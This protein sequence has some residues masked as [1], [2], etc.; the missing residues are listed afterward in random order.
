MLNAADGGRCDVGRA[1][2]GQTGSILKE[3]LSRHTSGHQR[4]A[5]NRSQRLYAMKPNYAAH[6]LKKKTREQH[7]SGYARATHILVSIPAKV[8]VLVLGAC[9]HG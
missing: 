1:V 8:S 2:V 4:D 6:D 3:N 5:Y 9:C 7:I